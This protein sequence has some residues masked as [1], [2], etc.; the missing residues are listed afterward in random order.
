[1]VKYYKGGWKE[2]DEA[3]KVVEAYKAQGKAMGDRG[4]T[5]RVALEEYSG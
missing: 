2:D 4:D 5:I 1:M 3:L